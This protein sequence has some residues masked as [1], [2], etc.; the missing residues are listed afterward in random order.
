LSF[1][2]GNLVGDTAAAADADRDGD[3]DFADF[4][5]FA[6]HFSTIAGRLGYDPTYDYDGN[7]AI[8][9]TDFLIFASHFGTTL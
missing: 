1:S 3:V 4:L 6:E 2:S 8:N 5:S 7:R 9:F